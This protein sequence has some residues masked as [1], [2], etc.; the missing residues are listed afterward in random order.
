MRPF[1]IKTGQRRGAASD[2][3]DEVHED[4]L[5]LEALWWLGAAGTRQADERD[6]A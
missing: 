2:L 1:L 3:R 6:Q 5:N 4:A